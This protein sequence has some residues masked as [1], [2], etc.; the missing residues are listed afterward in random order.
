[1]VAGLSADEQAEALDALANVDWS[2]WDA[3]E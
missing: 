3:M 1:M 2:S